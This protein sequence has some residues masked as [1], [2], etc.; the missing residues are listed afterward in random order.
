MAP[1][2]SCNSTYWRDRDGVWRYDWNA[3]VPGAR[4]LT[5]GEL[6]ALDPDASVIELAQSF[7]SLTSDE[8]DWLLARRPCQGDITIRRQGARPPHAGDL[9]VGL[10]APELQVQALMT[11]GDIAEAAQVSKATIDSYRYRGYL[12]EPQ[13][14]RGRTPLWARPIV[15]RWL[16][17][18]PGCG[19]RSDVYA[20]APGSDG[21]GS[22]ESDESEAVAG[23]A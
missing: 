9:V 22:A 18:R 11:V 1:I 3:V 20:A 4:D 21:D 5:L 8:L 19:W 10:Q 15:L 23:Q 12:P 13:V 6:L 16:S 17:N 2:R 7:R 14:T